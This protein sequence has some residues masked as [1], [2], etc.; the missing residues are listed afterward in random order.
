MAEAEP[1]A[2]DN[3]IPFDLPAPSVAAPTAG[4]RDT[5]KWPPGRP[6]QPPSTAT[7]AG[8]PARPPSAAAARLTAELPAR[9]PVGE[10]PWHT[11]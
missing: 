8:A 11:H 2:G 6:A 3:G 7:T 9:L 1:G 10:S 4:T 5:Y